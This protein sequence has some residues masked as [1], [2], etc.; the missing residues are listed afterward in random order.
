MTKYK[1][2]AELKR[3]HDNGEFAGRHF[4]II[5]DNDEVVAIVHPGRDDD[6]EELG[7]LEYAWDSDGPRDALHEAFSILGLPSRDC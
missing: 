6:G 5:V 4:E 7:D 3:A 2:L 1:T